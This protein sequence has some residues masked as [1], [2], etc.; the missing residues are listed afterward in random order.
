VRDP[1]KAAEAALK[2]LYLIQ[3]A[4]KQQQVDLD[5]DALD[6][7]HSPWLQMK[8]VL[9][10]GYSW[11]ALDVLSFHGVDEMVDRLGRIA[12]QPG[13]LTEYVYA[14]EFIESDC[15]IRCYVLDDGTG[16]STTPAHMRYTRPGCNDR[17]TGRFQGFQDLSREEAI[18]EWYGGSVAAVLKAEAEI[19]RLIRRWKT[20]LLCECS[21]VQPYMRFDFFVK[22]LGN[23]TSEVSGGGGVTASSSSSS[24][25]EG[26]GQGQGQTAGDD[27]VD[28]D[29]G[30]YTGE[31][32]ELGGSTL[33]WREG[34]QLIFRRVLQACLEGDQAPPSDSHVVV[35]RYE[36]AHIRFNS[37]EEEE[38]E[39]DDDDDEEEEDDEDDEDGGRY[40]N[41]CPRF[42]ESEK[43]KYF[44]TFG[45][46]GVLAVDSRG[47]VKEGE[48]G[49]DCN[50][51][52][53]LKR[54]K[55]SP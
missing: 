41:K 3:H 43:Q 33:N 36:A 31:L 22:R 55:L 25:G 11:E 52:A 38:E 40:D 49:G 37:D 39:G 28:L 17:D 23:R 6:M 20:W 16:L 19:E 54:A 30:I 15:E 10:L 42:Y 48:G 9:K 18:Q 1:Y 34:P 44:G 27:E 4:Q 2:A 53:A 14:Q 45:G 32:T 51:E 26:Q 50:P 24:V 35:R 47:E 46:G 12:E 13:C 7:S 8:G 29:L 21:E 5:L